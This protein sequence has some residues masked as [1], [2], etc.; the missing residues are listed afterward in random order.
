MLTC[1]PPAQPL[2]HSQALTAFQMMSGCALAAA[3]LPPR[4][5]APLPSRPDAAPSALGAAS[6]GRVTVD[7]FCRWSAQH[8]VEREAQGGTA[9]AARQAAAGSLAQVEIELD[10]TSIWSFGKNHCG[11]LGVGSWETDRQPPRQ[12][13]RLPRI[14][15]APAV[16]RLIKKVACGGRHTVLLSTSGEYARPSAQPTTPSEPAV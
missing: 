6:Q 15:P 5:P 4:P 12:D 2:E 3:P 1:A 9:P 8:S 7:N 10:S 14:D 13:V 16:P 11:Q